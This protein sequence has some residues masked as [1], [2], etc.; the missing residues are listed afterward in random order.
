MFKTHLHLGCSERCVLYTGGYGTRF[1]CAVVT[2]ARLCVAAVGCPAV[3]PPVGA[4]AFRDDD[5][6]TIRCNA[7]HETWYLTCDGEKWI[8]TVGNCSGS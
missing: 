7:T 3:R 2:D 6:A 5:T 8:G 1:S 4:T